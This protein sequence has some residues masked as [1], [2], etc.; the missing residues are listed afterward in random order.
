MT[1]FALLA[2]VMVVAASA[3]LAGERSGRR[4]LVVAAKPVAAAAFVLL[5][6]FGYT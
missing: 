5:A 2:L 6:W 3:V 4:W 1:D